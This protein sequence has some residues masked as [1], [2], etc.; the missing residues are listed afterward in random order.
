MANTFYII[1]KGA[2]N[3]WH[4]FNNGAKEVNISDFEAVLD[5]VSQ[6]FD[7]QNRNGS[8][9]P[10]TSVLITDVIV[11]DETDASVEEE[12]ISAEVLYNR[13]VQLQYTP[14]I[15]AT[16]IPEAPID[17]QTYGRKDGG[18][19]VVSS[20]GGFTPVNIY[21]VYDGTSVTVPAGF[22]VTRVVDLNDIY[23]AVSGGTIVSNEMPI[24]GGVSGNAYLIDGYK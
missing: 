17:G 8:N 23:N 11:I 19:V 10:K 12:F 6:T 13:L 15:S 22:T 9:I 7:I 21:E 5:T 14:Y 2:N 20:G 3:F 16:G 1:K 18:W 4:R 24:T